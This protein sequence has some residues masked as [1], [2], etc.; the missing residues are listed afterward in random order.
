MEDDLILGDEEEVEEMEEEIG[1]TYPEYISASVEVLT[2]LETANPMTREEVQKMQELKKL[3]LEMLEFSV[4]SMH[5]M[6]F[7]NDI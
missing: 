1:Y 4:K 5:G 6:L 3:C 2:M 7:T